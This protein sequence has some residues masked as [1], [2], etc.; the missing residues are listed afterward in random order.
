M[1]TATPNGEMLVIVERKKNVHIFDRSMRRLRH[2]KCRQPFA[3]VHPNA[4]KL[5][6][7]ND[8]IYFGGEY[9]NITRI[10]IGNLGILAATVIGDSDDHYYGVDDMLLSGDTL[11]AVGYFGG[12]DPPDELAAYD[13]RTLKRRFTF[14]VGLFRRCA[15]GLA[16][17]GTE[18]F[19][20]DNSSRRVQVFSL[21][22]EPLRVIER[23]P[24]SWWAPS[25]L[26][27]VDERLY[28]S[29]TYWEEEEVDAEASPVPTAEKKAAREKAEESIF[30]MSTT[31]ALLQKYELATGATGNEAGLKVRS[32]CAFA[33]RLFVHASTKQRTQP[34]PNVKP[35]AQSYQLVELQGL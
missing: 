18:L 30:V 27:A 29:E 23:S 17:V 13:S 10:S 2:V 28:V 25:S 34:N 26:I 33:G 8:S 15:L 19:V 14:G 22:G 6:A 4:A 32:M 31:G 9:P 12:G 7:S 3:A 24:L 20:A 1:M 16:Q 11:F 21:A 5:T 35:P